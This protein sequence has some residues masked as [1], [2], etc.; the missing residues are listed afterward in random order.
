[1]IVK[2]P[3]SARLQK[4]SQISI[5]REMIQQ[6]QY[7]IN[8]VKYKITSIRSMIKP[9]LPFNWKSKDQIQDIFT[10]LTNLKKRSCKLLNQK[11]NQDN[12]MTLI[13]IHKLNQSLVNYQ[14]QINIVQHQL[15]KY[16]TLVLDLTFNARF[17]I[18]LIYYQRTQRISLKQKITNQRLGKRLLANLI[19]NSKNSKTNYTQSTSRTYRIQLQSLDHSSNRSN[20]N[21]FITGQDSKTNRLSLSQLPPIKMK[22]HS[23]SKLLEVLQKVSFRGQQQPVNDIIEIYKQINIFTKKITEQMQEIKKKQ[24]QYSSIRNLLVYCTNLSLKQFKNK[25]KIT[26]YNGYANSIYFDFN[27]SINQS[28]T[29]YQSNPN[30]ERKIQNIL[31]D[32]LQQI[33]VNMIDA[34]QKSEQN[35]TEES[36]IKMLF[37]RNNLWN[38][39]LNKFWDYQHFNQD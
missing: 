16:F 39:I 33:M 1:M 17:A 2:A 21:L 27:T 26:N 37:K 24:N 12:K 5:K 8:M 31:Y 34:Q 28:M 29:D 7:R 9:Q 38:S 15:K 25:Q 23:K 3:K 32:T 22:K 14:K 20:I 11:K 4:Y 13:I 30:Q 10:Q 19:I 6:I 18:K 35:S 36:I